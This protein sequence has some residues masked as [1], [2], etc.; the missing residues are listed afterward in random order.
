MEFL[1][2]LFEIGCAFI[3]GGATVIVVQYFRKK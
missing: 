3:A 2:R 1:G